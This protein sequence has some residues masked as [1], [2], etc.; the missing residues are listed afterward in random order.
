MP[1]MNELILPTLTANYTT[2]SEQATTTTTTNDIGYA[3]AYPIVGG[4]S[5]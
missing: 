3:E 2:S 1:R 4:N 5:L